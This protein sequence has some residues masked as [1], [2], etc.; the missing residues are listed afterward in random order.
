MGKKFQLDEMGQLDQ[1][2]Q[3]VSLPAIHST[4]TSQDGQE[5]LKKKL[6]IFIYCIHF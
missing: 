2:G 5:S 3:N 1:S 6:Y 4:C